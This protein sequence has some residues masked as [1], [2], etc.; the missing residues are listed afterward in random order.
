MLQTADDLS[1]TKWLEDLK[2]LLLELLSQRNALTDE[3]PS[4]SS[5]LG[6]SLGRFYMIAKSCFKWSE[7]AKKESS[8]LTEISIEQIKN[9]QSDMISKV[10]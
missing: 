9:M 10:S 2:D 8:S 4:D 1:S 6:T 7:L 5:S 3:S